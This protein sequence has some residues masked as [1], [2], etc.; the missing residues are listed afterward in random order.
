M[1]DKK[2]NLAT[3]LK[4]PDIFLGQIILLVIIVL[5]AVQ[6]TLRFV[7]SAPL[8][9]PEE[10]SAILLLWLTFVGAV[11][12]TRRNDHIRVELVAEFAGPRVAAWLDVVFDAATV[13]FLALIISGGWDLV[14]LLTFEKTP[15]LRLRISAIV[16]I[17][18]IAAA[19]MLVFYVLAVFRNLRNLIRGPKG[20]N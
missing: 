20:G 2:L 16:A 9:W 4:E 14:N 12:L 18:P 19:I 1:N 15:A 3:I 7:F 17:V 8:T 6:V 5:T 13:V 10:L 11:A